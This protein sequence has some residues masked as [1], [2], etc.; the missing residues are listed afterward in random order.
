MVEL[1]SNY[2]NLQKTDDQV[3]FDGQEQLTKVVKTLQ[4]EFQREEDT[5]QNQQTT[6]KLTGPK[7]NTLEE[8]WV[9][10]I[11]EV[12]TQEHCNQKKQRRQ[13]FGEVSK[14]LERQK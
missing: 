12:A 3:T 8:H 14:F 7:K 10:L 2:Q 5:Q 4:K 9:T 6:V 11:L 1:D 13:G